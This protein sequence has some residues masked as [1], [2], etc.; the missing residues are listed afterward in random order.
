[1]MASSKVLRSGSSPWRGLVIAVA[2][3]AF[4]QGCASLGGV[5]PPL[6]EY[7]EEDQRR[8]RT[9]L[10]TVAEDSEIVEFLLDYRVL[11]Q[12]VRACQ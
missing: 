3:S 12:Q 10:A 2:L 1:M 11:R 8:L 9:E 6:V 4:L 5:C 7:S